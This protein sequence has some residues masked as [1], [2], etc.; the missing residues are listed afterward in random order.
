M[1]AAH[2]RSDNAESITLPG[3]A[4]HVEFVER[5]AE[6]SEGA[7]SE[8]Y[9]NRKKPYKYYKVECGGSFYVVKAHSKKEALQDA[10]ETGNPPTSITLALQGEIDYYKC[11]FDIEEALE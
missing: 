8:T 9:K 5:L 11:Y 2:L 1:A 10:N 4:S 3:V 7:M 6:A